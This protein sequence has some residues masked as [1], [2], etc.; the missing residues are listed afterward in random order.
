MLYI[1]ISIYIHMCACV[2]D[3][4]SCI[5]VYVDHCFQAVLLGAAVLGARASGAFPDV[6]SA[7]KAM[8]RAGRTILPFEGE[9]KAN[10]PVDSCYVFTS[11][12]PSP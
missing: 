7:M 10:S 11:L 2:L 3:N 12:S 8:N 6:P 9:N 1:N 4:C 5:C